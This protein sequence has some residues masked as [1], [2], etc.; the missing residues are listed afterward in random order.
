MNAI[1][2]EG[3]TKRFGSF[4][5]VSDLN[6]EVKQ[7]EI[8]GF[9]GPNGSG[10]TT[11]IKMLCGLLAPSAG[12]AS[13]LGFDAQDEGE[14]IRQN[15]GYM[16]QKFSLYEDLSVAENMRFYGSIY[17]L[18]ATKLNE[19]IAFLLAKLELLPY[20]ER[21]AG[22]LS[23]GWKQRLA[24]ACAII[25]EPKVLFLDEPTAGIDPVARRQLWDIFFEYAALGVTFF[26]TT[27]YMD[28]AERC[29]SLGYIYLSKLVINGSLEEIRH[30]P[31]INPQGYRRVEVFATPIAK[32]L[33]CLKNYDFVKDATIFGRSVHLLYH[34][35][36]SIEMILKQLENDG[37]TCE[38]IIPL[39]PSLEDAFVSFTT[40]A[41][42]NAQ[43]I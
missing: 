34:E 32:A 10:K 19:R 24:F 11:V 38:K 13:V 15:V 31:S 33:A 6:I 14:M 4:T 20:Q 43:R 29:G 36:Y 30:H 39:E 37:V 41:D 27:H 35:K 25:H 42:E 26:V 21:L 40:M 1:S 17:G 23:G 16:S 2:T 3:L 5:A 28:E 9:L 7:G 8:Y 12:K 22:K 18:N